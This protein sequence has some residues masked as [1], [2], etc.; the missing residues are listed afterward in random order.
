MAKD[1]GRWGQDGRRDRCAPG[2][3][4][5]DHDL[6]A[7]YRAGNPEAAELLYRRYADRLTALARKR[8]LAELAPRVDSDDIVQSAFGS[9]FRGAQ[10]GAYDVPPGEEI[11]CLLAAITLN[12]IHA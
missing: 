8:N 7:R 10:K 3:A 11:W 9:F 12:K 5:S 1:N 6:L 2:D 4:P